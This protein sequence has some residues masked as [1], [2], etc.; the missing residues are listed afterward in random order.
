[1]NLPEGS[2]PQPA[3]SAPAAAP[4]PVSDLD[5]MQYRQIARHLPGGAVFLL[6]TDLVY[7]LA[8]GEALTQ[9]GMRSDDL[10]GKS[11][12]EVMG[13]HADAQMVAD[14][15]QV[16]AGHTFERQ[17]RV[18]TRHYLSRGAPLRGSDG[19]VSAAL[20][21]SFDITPMVAAQQALHEADRQKDEFLAVLAHEMRGPLSPLLNGF[22]LLRLTTDKPEA[23]ARTRTMM[24]RQLRL[25]MRL[26]DNLMDK[27]R[28][29][30]GK[31]QLRRQRVLLSEVLQL[32][33]DTASGLIQQKG[34]EL[35]MRQPS[36]AVWLDADPAR[37]AQVFTNLLHNSAK[38]S[39]RGSRV[40]L[41]VQTHDAHVDVEV[42]DNGDGI[43]P[44]KLT[45]VF[46]LFMQ[47]DDATQRSA[48]GLGIGLALVKALV[49]AHG[50]SVSAFSGGIG[51]GSR[52][53]V[54]L[55]RA[56]N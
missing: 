55:P 35:L 32:A 47:L 23:N 43:P 54:R 8:D 6:D 17:H 45:R 13:D 40:E 28:I 16:L 9:A 31:L 46:D 3:G 21:T 53:T 51:L 19:R 33:V 36:G 37:L 15:R 20:V 18:G 48:G 50:G 14:Y 44:D 49:E 1:M 7:R 4:P 38:Y 42:L 5:Q 24:E 41:R 56:P 39:P 25:L 52:F 27:S 10:E 22:E 2:T 12:F 30:S 29:R 11:L 34:H 26:V